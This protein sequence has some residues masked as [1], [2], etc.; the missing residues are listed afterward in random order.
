MVSE[1][2]KT[3]LKKLVKDRP[4][5]IPIIINV[6]D[7]NIKIKKIKLLASRQT[8]FSIILFNARK[9]INLLHQ[10][11]IFLFTDNGCLVSSNKT[12]GDIYDLH[13]DKENEVLMINLKM[14]NTFGF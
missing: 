10:Q 1:E 8:D 2:D 11:A 14:E 5:Y 12:I 13:G 6:D 7:K 4:N 3:C 9:K